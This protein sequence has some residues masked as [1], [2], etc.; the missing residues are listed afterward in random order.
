MV[1]IR[2]ARIEVFSRSAQSVVAVSQTDQ[3]GHF[4]VTVPF[5]PSLTVRVLSRLRTSNLRVADNTNLNAVYAVSSDFDGRQLNLS[6]V[7]ADTSRVSGAFNILE[8]VQRA[9]ETIRIADP[10]LDPPQVT[11]FWSTKNTR[12]TGNVAQG[13]IGT[14][15][16][17]VANNTA[18]ILG[19]RNEDSDEF[20]DSV[21]VHEYGHMLAAKFSRDDSP[22]GETHLGDILDPRVAWSEGWANFF[23]SVVRNDPV[24]RDNSG[25]NGTNVY[26]FDLRDKIPTGDK[27][28]YWSEMSVGSLLWELY[29]GSDLTGSNS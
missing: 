17:N 16:F 4:N 1:P 21:I 11:I 8:M 15:F 6:V 20:D 10:S 18:F 14:S 23:S 27:P 2:N 13:L 24:W 3:R 19:D 9:N 22:G 5:D 28:G 26:R 12:R 25:P 7:L 29:Q